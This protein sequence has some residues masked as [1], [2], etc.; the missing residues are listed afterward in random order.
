M[1][2]LQVLNSKCSACVDDCLSF[3]VALVTDSVLPKITGLQYHHNPE[4]PREAMAGNG[5]MGG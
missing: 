1:G 2:A 3:C 5:C 4:Y